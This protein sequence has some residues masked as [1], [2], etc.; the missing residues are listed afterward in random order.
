ML[1]APML[2]TP[3]VFVSRRLWSAPAVGRFCRSSAY[4]YVDG[5]SRRPDRFRS[6][7]VQGFRLTANVTD[8][9]FSGIYF[10]AVP[11]E[12][13]LTGYFV[14]HLRPGAVFVDVGANCGYFSMLAA[15][16]VGPSGRVFS[17]EPNP[18]GSASSPSTSSGT[19]CRTGCASSNW[20]SAIGEPTMLRCS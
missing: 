9:V 2:E 13:L 17:F 7:T 18:P 5:L 1:A 3:F 14:E 12:P 6:V 10:G 11:Y 4:R 8:F 16:L 15:G 20:R 19:R